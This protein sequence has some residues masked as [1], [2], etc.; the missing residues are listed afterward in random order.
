[1]VA[2]NR[3]IVGCLP[4]CAGIEQHTADV[5]HR[6]AIRLWVKRQDFL[7]VRVQTH[8]PA[9]IRSVGRAY[10]DRHRRCQW[11]AALVLSDRE[12]AG[13][14]RFGGYYA[15]IRDGGN[16]ALPFIIAEVEGLILDDRPAD[17]RAEIIAHIGILW[18]PVW[19]SRI[20]EVSRAQG[21]VASKPVS[22]PVQ[23]VGATRGNDFDQC[24]VIASVFR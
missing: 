21:V 14:E 6:R 17:R 8:T 15:R 9:I 18:A 10:I 12:F 24:P 20:E 5:R 13:F 4:G 23:L 7:Y 1:M 22:R 11:R 19:P 16:E 3:K 2:F